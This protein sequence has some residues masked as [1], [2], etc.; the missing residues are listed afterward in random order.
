MKRRVSFAGKFIGERNNCFVVAEAGSNHNG[1]VTLGKRLIEAA[2]ECGCDAVKFQAFKTENL[3][4]RKAA[5]A[6]YQKQK[7]GGASQYEMLKGVELSAKKHHALVKHANTV[8]IPIF[9][10]VFDEDSADL[11]EGLGIDIFKL[12]SGELTNIPLIKYIA[13]KRKPLILSTGMGTDAEISDAVKA[14]RQE[15]GGQLILMNCSTGYPA[16]PEEANLRRIKYLEKK[17]KVLCGSSDHTQGIMVSVIAASLGACVVEKHF[18][19]SK[20]LSGPDH[21]MSI[22]PKE[23]KQLCGIIRIAEKNPVGEDALRQVMREVD[24]EIGQERLR[25]ILGRCDRVLSKTEKNQRIWARKSVV[26]LRD[27]R[28]GEVFSQRN[29]GVRRPESGVLPGDYQRLL[30]KRTGV[31]IRKESH[32]KWDMLA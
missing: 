1:S 29:I 3:V 24:I 20:K 19:I 27:I 14:F 25:D 4:T 8:G 2:K 18:T 31:F 17:F 32:I 6:E 9:Y 22:E 30:G 13:K 15:G 11:I 12:G 26:A 23:M 28:K 10:S 5:K 21:R 16:R 7:S